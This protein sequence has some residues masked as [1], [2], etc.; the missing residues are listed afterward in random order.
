MSDSSASVF[1]RQPGDQHWRFLWLFLLL[2]AIFLLTPLLLRY[3]LLQFA[4]SVLFLFGL[5]VSF[6]AAGFPPRWRRLLAT[7]WVLDV[8]LLLWSRGT[9]DPE[10]AIV[11]FT[12]ARVAALLLLVACVTGT[13]RYVLASPRVTLDTIFAAI[14]AYQLAALAFAVLYH[15]I[16]TSAP[17]SFALPPDAPGEEHES[18][19][20]RM[21]YF[22]FVTIATL[23]YGDIV[24]HTPL[25]QMIATV[26]ATLGQFYIAVVIAWLVGLHAAQVHSR[27]KD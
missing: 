5:Y 1:P 19:L 4:L 18:L 12:A 13:L 27:R 11:L 23:G 17:H 10:M 2:L 15:L 21:I 22:S 9:G 8:A 24:P 16:A 25:T 26:E 20:V 6:S 7:L 14:V 3:R